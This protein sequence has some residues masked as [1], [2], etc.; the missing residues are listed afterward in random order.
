MPRIA[1]LLKLKFEMAYRGMP[2][3]KAETKFN[4]IVAPPST[5][6]APPKTDSAVSIPVQSQPSK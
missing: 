3:D 5:E 2:K 4:E 1:E 6:P